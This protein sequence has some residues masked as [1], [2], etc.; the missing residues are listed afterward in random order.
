[1]TYP[2]PVNE[3]PTAPRPKPS[4]APQTFTDY[5]EKLLLKI[6]IIGVITLAAFLAI[7]TYLSRTHASRTAAAG[8]AAT[9]SPPTQ[10]VP[11]A[12]DIALT[13]DFGDGSQLVYPHLP[14][15]SGMTVLDAMN[16]TKGLKRPLSF[17]TKGSGET[18]MI[19]SIGDLANEG[20]GKLSR[21]WLYRVNDKPATASAAVTKLNCG[22]Q[23]LWRFQPYS[24]DQP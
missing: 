18:L 16:I 8:P 3:D 14:H 12:T 4:R 20:G 17:E 10:P 13:I 1:M 15:S 9:Q 24:P 22:D 5:L 6:V 19:T 21:N 2:H 11:A 23:V 7:M